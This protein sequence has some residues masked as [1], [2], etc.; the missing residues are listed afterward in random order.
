M[1]GGSE[2]GKKGTKTPP[3]QGHQPRESLEEWWGHDSGH[4]MSP[5]PL[6]APV[7]VSAV[8][9]QFLLCVKKTFSPVNPKATWVPPA[10]QHRPNPP[11]KNGTASSDGSP[12]PP[13]WF[14]CPCC[15]GSAGRML[16]L[17]PVSMVSPH[18]HR[19]LLR[20]RSCWQENKRGGRPGGPPPGLRGADAIPFPRKS[21]VS[22]PVSF[23]S[24]WGR[25][26]TPP[27]TP[28]SWRCLEIR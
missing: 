10:S 26:P 18:L 7:G 5:N 6:R 21:G 8:I 25:C 17:T 3:E 9:D 11:Q 27:S 28:P 4:P 1:F 12:S 24:P 22:V 14:W 16:I 20:K 19:I 15:P 13:G 2:V 23:P